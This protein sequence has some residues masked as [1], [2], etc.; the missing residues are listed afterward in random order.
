MYQQFPITGWISIIFGLLFML[1]LIYSV[2]KVVDTHPNI[3]LRSKPDEELIKVI[4]DPELK[5]WH[6]EAHKLL[7]QRNQKNKP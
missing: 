7:N 2:K 5:M 4:S 1:S 3:Q 6:E